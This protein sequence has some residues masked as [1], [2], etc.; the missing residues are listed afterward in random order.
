MTTVTKRCSE[1]GG[2]G[3]RLGLTGLSVFAEGCAACGGKP[4]TK[5]GLE[6]LING[7]LSARKCVNAAGNCKFNSAGRCYSCNSPQRASAARPR[8]R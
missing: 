5:R 6:R 8:A 2:R 3:F 7:M 1:C 4:P